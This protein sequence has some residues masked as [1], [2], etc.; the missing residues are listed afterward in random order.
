M[1]YSDFE[2]TEPTNLPDFVSPLYFKLIEQIDA[3]GGTDNARIIKFCIAYTIYCV[4]K[5]DRI[6]DEINEGRG[7]NH[8]SVRKCFTNF[9]EEWVIDGLIN[10]AKDILADTIK[11]LREASIDPILSEVKASITEAKGELTGDITRHTQALETRISALNREPKSPGRA[12]FDFFLDG[13]KHAG[14]LIIAVAFIT[15]IAGLVEFI[16]PT[17]LKSIVHVVEDVI[18]AL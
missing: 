1:H 13:I 7:V 5:K 15:L 9:D 12:L 17:L 18:R 11:E 6:L 2:R 3:R 14:H 10:A 8:V 4:R 16:W